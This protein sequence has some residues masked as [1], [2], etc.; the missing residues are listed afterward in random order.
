MTDFVMNDEGLGMN[1]MN[2][3]EFCYLCALVLI[4][5]YGYGW[6]YGFLVDAGFSGGGVRDGAVA[7]MAESA[8]DGAC[9][10]GAAEGVL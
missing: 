10:A 5:C 7:G 1:D 8:G 6:K 3:G 2:D 9:V 4:L